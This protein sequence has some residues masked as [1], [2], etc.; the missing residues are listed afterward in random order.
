MTTCSS[1]YQRQSWGHALPCLALSILG[2]L[3][4]MDSRWEEKVQKAQRGGEEQRCKGLG[5]AFSEQ[6]FSWF[7][8][9]FIQD[10]LCWASCLGSGPSNAGTEIH[11]FAHSSI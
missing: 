3:K 5:W 11:M 6:S 10:P 9:S 2:C 4:G 7:L 8:L 1:S